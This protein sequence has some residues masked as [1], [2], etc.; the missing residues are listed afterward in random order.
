[1]QLGGVVLVNDKAKQHSY[2]LADELDDLAEDDLP[3]DELLAEPPLFFA[4]PPADDFEEPPL[5]APPDRPA[6]FAAVDEADRL[7]EPEPDFAELLEEPL[8]EDDLDVPP[9]VFLPPV[10]VDFELPPDFER[11]A[12]FEAP[13]DLELLPDDFE[14]PPADLPPLFAAVPEDL[15]DELPDF[16]AVEPPDFFAVEP[17]DRPDAFFEV[18]PEDFRADDPPDG[19]FERE[20]EVLL[21]PPPAPEPPPVP[22]VAMSAAVAAAPITAPRAA[23][24]ASSVTISTAP[25]SAL[26]KVPFPPP[27]LFFVDPV[28]CFLVAAIFFCLLVKFARLNCG[29]EYTYAS[30]WAHLQIASVL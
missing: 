7:D 14:A 8:P 3:P 15:D 26:S 1:M 17:D 19:D 13:V 22:S 10:L 9:E 28:C 21:V 12:D 23:P 30:A 11:P 24:V 25:S 20:P 29:R 18:D 27:D 6:D 4:P 5:F 2:F 16:L